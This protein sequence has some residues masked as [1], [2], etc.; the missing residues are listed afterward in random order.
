MLTLC[1][2]NEV[3]IMYLNAA[4]CIYKLYRDDS[5]HLSV[6][7]CVEKELVEKQI[8]QKDTT[9]IGNQYN[10]FIGRVRLNRLSLEVGDIVL[11]Y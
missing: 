6:R 2:S 4:I 10:V 1:C 5:F 7:F 11:K 9:Q 8:H 3:A